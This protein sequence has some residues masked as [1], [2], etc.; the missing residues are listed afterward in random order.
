MNTEFTIMYI[1]YVCS[2]MYKVPRVN[3]FKVTESN[4]REKSVKLDYSASRM[5]LY[6]L[7]SKFL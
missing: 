3:N 7:S 1:I 4:I 2:N 5:V 6:N